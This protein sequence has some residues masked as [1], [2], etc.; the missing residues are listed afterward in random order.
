M[1]ERIESVIRQLD[2]V[3]SDVRQAFGGLSVDQLNWAPA[4][5]RWSIAQCLDH[6]IVMNSLYFPEFEALAAGTAKPTFWQR[7]SPFSGFFGRLLI[8][9]LDP[10]NQRRTKTS[11][12][13]HPD[14][15]PIDREI[16]ERFSARQA[17]L[18][19][20]LRTIPD[21]VDP[22]RTILTSPLAAFVT[23][24]L[25][26]AFTLLVVHEKRHVDQAKRVM[27]ADGFPADEA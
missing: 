22:A 7:F 23:Y 27:A 13:A 25:D 6:L 15:R 2:E 26:D 16:V 10:A 19:D 3:T 11:R 18:I 5:G 9:S 24:S 14:A 17:E 21:R 4:P 1:S 20:H 8:R 12:K